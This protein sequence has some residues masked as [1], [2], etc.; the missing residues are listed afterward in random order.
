MSKIIIIGLPRT[1]TTS[2]SVCLLEAGFK[3]AHTAFTKET[4]YLADVISDAPCFSDFKQLDQ[5]F[6]HS[7][8]IYLEREITSWVPSIQRLL[9]KMAP[10]LEAKAG[11]FSPVLKRSFMDTFNTDCTQLLSDEHLIN[12]YQQHQQGVKD[13]FRGRTDLL[14]ID[15]SKK[16]SFQQLCDFLSLPFISGQIFP[17]LNKGTQVS[18]WK[19]Y[20]HPNK[21]NS[22]SAG[23]DHRQFF[24]YK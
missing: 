12:C 20:K 3:V 19:S 14:S 9:S 4:F 22:Y 2:I 11:H 24:D 18:K 23:R 21:I 6:P 15:L 10:H 1:G 8:F 13:Y 16:E 5:L 17:H 7:T